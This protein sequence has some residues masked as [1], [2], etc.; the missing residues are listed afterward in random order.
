MSNTKHNKKQVKKVRDQSKEVQKSLGY[1]TTY[2]IEEHKKTLAELHKK[3]LWALAF[4][5]P[6]AAEL[7]VAVIGFTMVHMLSTVYPSA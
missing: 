1:W 7:I 2:S 6:L 5:R 4:G 3:T